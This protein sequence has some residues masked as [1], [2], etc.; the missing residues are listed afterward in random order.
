MKHWT[1]V[2]DWLVAL[3]VAGAVVG[4]GPAP[5]SRDTIARGL[6]S[7]MPNERAAAAVMA[8]DSGDAQLV[9]LLVERLEDE[10]GEVRLLS[11]TALRRITGQTMEYRCGGSLAD[12]AVAVERWRQWMKDHPAQRGPQHD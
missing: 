10:D 3:M 11:C 4:C 7:E 1:I 5:A 12:R 6:Q 8:G 2:S 9:P